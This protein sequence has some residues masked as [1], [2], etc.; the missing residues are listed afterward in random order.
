MQNSQNVNNMDAIQNLSQM[1]MLDYMDNG[2]PYYD[3]NQIGN[4][5]NGNY[6][7][8]MNN[9][10]G[11]AGQGQY[12]KNTHHKSDQFVRKA[13]DKHSPNEPFYKNW[14]RKLPDASSV[15]MVENIDPKRAIIFCGQTPI[16]YNK[17][18]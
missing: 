18:L 1:F 15:D 6:Q 14:K 16:S 4:K 10:K 2:K 9:V 12:K 5:N 7:K 17:L 13:K 11:N 3:K 8:K